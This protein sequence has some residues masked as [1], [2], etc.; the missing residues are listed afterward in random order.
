MDRV[1]DAIRTSKDCELINV[2]FDELVVSLQ[3]RVDKLE[4]NV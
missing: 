2:A 1:S 3:K 4:K